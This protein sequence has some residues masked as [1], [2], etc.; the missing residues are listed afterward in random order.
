MRIAQQFLLT[1][2]AASL[3]LAQPSQKA[4]PPPSFSL[5]ASVADLVRAPSELL[6]D[7]AMTS[8]SDRGVP[9]GVAFGPPPWK[10][11]LLDVRDSAGKPVSETPFLRQERLPATSGGPAVTLGPGATSHTVLVL[12]SLYDL[13]QPGEYTVQVGRLD[14]ASGTTVKSSP[15]VLRVPPPGQIALASKPAF[16][17]AVAALCASVQT[18]WRIPVEIAVTNVSPQPIRL[19]VWRGHTPYHELREAE[20]FGSGIEIHRQGADVR[21][22]PH[23]QAVRRGEEL[24]DGAFALV[25]IQPGAVWKERRAIGGFSGIS[26]PGSYTIQVSLIDPASGLPVKSNPISV[27]VTDPDQS[28]S[29]RSESRPPFIVTLRAEEEPHDASGNVRR[30]PV[31]LCMTNISGRQIALDNYITKDR[32]EVWDSRGEPVPITKD[33]RFIRTS[34]DGGAAGGANPIRPGDS[35]CGDLNLGPLYDL[36][37]PGVYSA[38]VARA[39]ELDMPPGQSLAGAPLVRSNVI[40][41]VVGGATPNREK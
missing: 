12:N 27:T 32:I 16:S 23:G 35:L 14:E 22:T 34:F 21:L 8:I 17:V 20:E 19:A 11:F 6:L 15:V 13:S 10:T 37:K 2:L 31:L 24:P 30:F 18:G 7:I 28:A 29:A 1:V 4:A 39:D 26:V 3:S 38:Q 40:P 33:G 5:A 41:L 25:S 36:S 9:L